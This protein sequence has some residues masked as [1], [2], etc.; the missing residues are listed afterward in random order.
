MEVLRNELKYYINYSDYLM[1]SK[2]LG[3]VL[4]PDQHS[5][6]KSGYFIRSLYFDSVDNHS[7]HE[8]LAGIENRRKYRLR[9][10][11]FNHNTVKFEI[12]H[13]LNNNIFKETAVISKKD[14]LR[15]LNQDYDVL[16]NYKDKVLN[17]IYCTFKKEKYFPVVAVDYQREAY[18][19]SLNKI[20]I[21]FDRFLAK[22]S[23]TLD[24]FNPKMNT[25]PVLDDNIVIMEIKY[26]RFLPEWVK[27]SLQSVRG[28]QCSI[29]K[30]CLSRIG[31]VE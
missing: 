13:K 11:G 20:R 14:A 28:V 1:I 27:K 9:I 25:L 21:T 8:K 26:N 31:D 17:K 23:T 24:F 19:S 15:V 3:S 7:F 5:S 6:N 16:L 4:E 10:Y 12:K 18:V 2:I 22:N 29:S 30:Y